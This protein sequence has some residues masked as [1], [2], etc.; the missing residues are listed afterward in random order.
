MGGFHLATMSLLS[1]KCIIDNID[2]FGNSNTFIAL[3]NGNKFGLRV[4]QNHSKIFN[5]NATYFNGEKTLGDVLLSSKHSC[6]AKYL[7]K[8]YNR[9]INYN[10]LLPV[11]KGK[12]NF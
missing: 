3:T 10:S 11:T 4:M 1:R 7:M 8:H 5:I 12:E 9:Q 6:V 2:K